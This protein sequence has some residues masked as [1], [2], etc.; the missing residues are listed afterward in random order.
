MDPDRA[1][2]ILYGLALAGIVGVAIAVIV[3]VVGGGSS[4][5]GSPEAIAA[6]MKA[7]GCTLTTSKAAPSAQHISKVTDPVTYTTFPPVS[8]RHYY[9]PAIWGNYTQIVDPRQAVHNEEHGGIDIWVGPGVSAAD[10]Q[11]ISDFY[12][13]SPNAILVTPIENTTAG[14]TY[15]PHKPPDGKIYLTSWTTQI[16]SG[17]PTNGK[18]VIA[19]C[20]HFDEKAFTAFR[21]QFRGKGPE[22]FPV[23]SLTPGT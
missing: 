20:P 7:A 4:K 17:S 18:N 14:I 9:I 6:T 19:T 10:R 11:K 23:S 2:K 1:K 16:S 15:P 12:D 21:D 8:G 22:R 5:A 3:V 13:S